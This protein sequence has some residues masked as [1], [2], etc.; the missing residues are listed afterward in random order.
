M[1]TVDRFYE[2]RDRSLESPLA[3]PYEDYLLGQHADHP[4]RRGP[5]RARGS[6]AQES[7]DTLILGGRTLWNGLLALG[8]CG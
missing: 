6:K 2:G 3:F 1:V 5:R 8:V 7:R 4:P